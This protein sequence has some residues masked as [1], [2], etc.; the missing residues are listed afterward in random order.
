MPPPSGWTNDIIGISWLREIFDRETKDKARRQWRLLILDGHGSHVT[1]EFIEY[2]YANKIYLLTYPPH[3]THS[4]QPLDVGIF[5]PLAKAY[6]DRLEEFLHESQG[7][8]SLT[9]RDFF[10]L[11]FPSWEKAL[12]QKNIKSAWRSVGLWPFNPE[13]VLAR[14]IR[15]DDERPSSSESSRSILQAEDWRRIERLL[16]DVVSDFYDQ[17]TKKL[18]STIHHLSTENILLKLRC[19]G[20]EK[21]IS[22][23][24]KKR[25][26]GKPI[27]FELQAPQDGGAV[28]YSPKK[29]QQF[30]DLQ[31]AKEVEI[32]AIKA[33]KEQDKL[34]RQQEKEEKQRLVQER[35]RIRASQR[36][37]R[38]QQVEEKKRQKEEARVAKEAS[39]QRQNDFRSA[40]KG[41]NKASKPSVIQNTGDIAPQGPEEVVKASLP[42][43]RRGRQ[44]RLP[45]R[46]RES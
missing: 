4:L 25:Q 40:R 31:A 30:R 38:L 15:N 14:F 35:K 37:I 29:I 22:T 16:K 2:C 43:N 34:R 42:T 23:E 33:S 11:F 26:R 21:A 8:C 9:K 45:Q 41:R 46:F 3:S 32:Q 17:N 19:Q 12:S 13:V 28:F 20:L 1:K 7:L 5:S 10:R 39:V 24:Q 36:G 27:T 18:S 6:S 44:I